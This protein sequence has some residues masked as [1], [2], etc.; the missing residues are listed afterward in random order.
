MTS[1][2]FTYF[3]F[4]GL[5]HCNPTNEWRF[6]LMTTVAIVIGIGSTA[7]HSTLHWF[8]QSMDE[9]PMLWF[10]SICC[11]CIYNN[12]TKR[13][14]KKEMVD[15]S[16]HIFALV[17]IAETVIYYTFQ[18]LYFV[19]IITY[20]V[21]TSVI[22]IWCYKYVFGR[23][24]HG[25]NNV[26]ALQLLSK[27][28]FVSFFVIGFVCWM[29]DMN[30]CSHLLPLYSQVSGMTLHVIWHLGAGYG[31]YLATLILVICRA[32]ALEVP[33][34]IKWMCKAIP[35]VSRKETSSDG[36]KD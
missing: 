7:L 12:D 34:D 16:A 29:V 36:K 5:I 17:T 33:V 32:N 21:S 25:C 3:G 4:L 14:T 10:N 9:I 11:Y 28:V 15:T 27:L 22:V 20:T 35:I 31:G 8:F 19:F 2:I 26:E 23:E 6:T 30:L 13:D 1:L 18:S 24:R